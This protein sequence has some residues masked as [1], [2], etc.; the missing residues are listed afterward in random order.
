VDGKDPLTEKEKSYIRRNKA[1][2]L[3]SKASESLV[4]SLKEKYPMAIRDE[5]LQLMVED[6]P[7]DATVVA[8]VGQFQIT[9][10]FLRGYGTYIQRVGRPQD[11]GSWRKLLEGVHGNIAAYEESLEQGYNSDKTV[12]ENINRIRK[13]V[14]ARSLVKKIGEEIDLTDREMFLHYLEDFELIAV[15]GVFSISGADGLTEEQAWLLAGELED[16]RVKVKDY[17]GRQGISAPAFDG[18]YTD[19]DLEENII[20]EIEKTPV[21]DISTPVSTQSGYAVFKVLGKRRGE[22]EPFDAYLERSRRKIYLQKA[23][24]TQ[25]EIAI[26]QKSRVALDYVYEQEVLVQLIDDWYRL[27]MAIKGQSP[28]GGWHG[29]PGH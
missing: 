15:E 7:D 17:L 26:R 2:D 14:L 11:P 29:G 8:T 20:L 27:Q 5:K 18:T 19:R 9:Q 22:A 4:D 16:G 1:G 6:T 25:Q 28:P 24:E 13:Y 21:G 23:Y 10:R 12:A 3:K